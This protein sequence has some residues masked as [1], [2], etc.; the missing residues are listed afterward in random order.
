MSKRIKKQEQQHEKEGANNV[1]KTKKTQ[2]PV[3][4]RESDSDDAVPNSQDMPIEHEDPE[5][6]AK[7]PQPGES[8][9]EHT[10]R[11]RSSSNNVRD[12]SDT[13]I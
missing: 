1:G 10:F 6:E 7:T 11:S 5:D 2:D 13:R 4:D 12:K 3:P 9:K 8:E